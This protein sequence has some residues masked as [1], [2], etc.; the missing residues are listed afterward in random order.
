MNHTISSKLKPIFAVS[1]NMNQETFSKEIEHHI[2]LEHYVFLTKDEEICSYID[3]R[4]LKISGIENNDLRSDQ[5]RAHEVPI[6]NIA[7]FK[8]GMSIT[9]PY[10]YK[11]LGNSIVLVKNK[12]D[13]IIGYVTRED[14]LISMFRKEKNINIL[15][16]LLGSIPMGVFVVDQDQKIINCNET[17]LNMIQS[18]SSQVMGMDAGQIFNKQKLDK[19]FDTGAMILNDIHFTNEMGVLVDYSPIESNNGKVEGAIIIVQDLPKV[20]EMALEMEA[21]KDLNR[22][23]N[24]ILSTIYDELLVIDEEGTLL[25]HSENYMKDFWPCDLKDLIGENIL[26]LENKGHFSPSV[27]RMVL[28]KREKVSVVQETNT[29]K[30]ILAVG[31]PIFNSAGDLQRIVVASRDI[32]ESTRLKSELEQTRERSK[33]YEQE[34]N[35]LK[36]RE[37]PFQDIIYGS[38]KMQK[39]VDQIDKIANFSSTVLILGESGVG[40]ELIARAIHKRSSRSDKPFLTINCGSIPEN[41]LESELFGYTK[42][43]FTGADSNGKKGYFEKADGGILFLD[44]IGDMPMPL[45]VKLLR[46]LQEGEVVP[47]GSVTPIPIDVQIVAATNKDLKTMVQQGNFREDLY[48]RINVIPIHVPP[49]GERSEDVPLLAYHTLEKLNKRYD[50]NY[51]LSPEA[52]NLLESYS[53]PG[54]I[55]E[56]QNLIERLFVTADDEVITAELVGHFLSDEGVEKPRPMINGIIPLHQAKEEIEEQLIMLAMKKYKTTTKAAQALGISQ[57]AVSRKY[58]QIIQRK[59]LKPTFI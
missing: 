14:M 21:V 15:K 25:R 7:V 46:V 36:N 6:D 17:G 37:D 5:I 48:Y 50:K 42:G 23:M 8:P 39:I 26:E 56:L 3:V 29:G 40:K 12:E 1:M 18:E 54:N 55:R 16:L 10:V 49:L 30:K 52:L 22:D 4:E 31:N 45:Q 41:L 51:H 9:L 58:N 35:R 24:A 38:L 59:E 13:E 57:S 11:V 2:N 33:R 43:S 19:I 44:E 28:E 53:W 47:I 20:G 34:L 32:T 27:I